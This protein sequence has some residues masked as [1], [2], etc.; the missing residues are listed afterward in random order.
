MAR[1]EMRPATL[2]F[3]ADVRFSNRPFG[4]KRFQ[5]IHHH[6]VDQG[7]CG[8]DRGG[9]EAQPTPWLILSIAASA[10][11]RRHQQSFAPSSIVAPNRKSLRRNTLA[12]TVP[13][14]SPCWRRY[15]H[16]SGGERLDLHSVAKFD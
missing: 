15:R 6:D 14:N 9:V 4:V 5:T 1:G 3:K 10:G 11:A 2:G 16:G 12:R 13:T 7:Q 8:V